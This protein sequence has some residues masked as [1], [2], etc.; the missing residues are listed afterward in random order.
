MDFGNFY[1]FPQ[2]FGLKQPN[3]R[4][5]KVYFCLVVRGVYLPYT[6][7]GPTNKKKFS[8]VSI[9]PIKVFYALPLGYVNIE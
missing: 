1:I 2:I 9:L 7:S 8:C 5:K 6:L 3:F 4:E